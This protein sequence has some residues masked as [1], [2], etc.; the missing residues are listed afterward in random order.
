MYVFILM[1]LIKKIDV[2]N[3]SEF[4]EAW[5]IQYIKCKVKFFC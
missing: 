3:L 1:K 2:N 4:D 5:E